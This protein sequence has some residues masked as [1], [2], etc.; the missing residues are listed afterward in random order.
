MSLLLK[1]SNMI[2]FGMLVH[3]C[4]GVLSGSAR[5]LLGS[6]GLRRAL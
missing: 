3:V 6:G 4:F 2:M 5:L 1:W